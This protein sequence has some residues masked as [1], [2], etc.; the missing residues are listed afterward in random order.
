MDSD[1]FGNLAL[2][3]PPLRFLQRINLCRWL[4][5]DI[6]HIMNITNEIH[7]FTE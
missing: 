2:D 6:V 4:E 5:L 3:I 7:N 1:G